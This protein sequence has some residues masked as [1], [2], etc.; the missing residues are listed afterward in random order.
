VF[1]GEGLEQPL[2]AVHGER[3]LARRRPAR[4]PAAGTFA[5]APPPDSGSIHGPRWC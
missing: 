2:V 1:G 4:L 5:M 3:S